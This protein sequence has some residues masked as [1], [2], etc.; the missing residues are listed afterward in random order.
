MVVRLQEQIA[1]LTA[2]VAGLRAENA[3][4]QRRSNRQAAPFSKRTLAKQPKRPGRKPGEGTFSFR[5]APHP[6]EITE[7]PQDV[8]VTLEA[9]PG[10]GGK[11]R[12]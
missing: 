11:L 3:E 9:C 5:Q 8:P 6:K 4:L 7:P 1:D 2:I 10:C 12:D